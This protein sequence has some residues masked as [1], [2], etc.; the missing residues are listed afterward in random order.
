MCIILERNKT[1]CESVL[2]S[3]ISLVTNGCQNVGRLL[4]IMG[5]NV[6]VRC[7]HGG[8]G[9]AFKKSCLDQKALETKANRNRVEIPE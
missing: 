1:C 5:R 9:V 6:C 8:H 7:A 4:R 3:I 2:R